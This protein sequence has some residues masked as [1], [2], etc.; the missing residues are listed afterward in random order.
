MELLHGTAHTLVE[1]MFYSLV[2]GAVLALFVALVLRLIPRKNAGTRFALWFSV[3]LAMIVLPFAGGSA[4]TAMAM[5]SQ[6]G[7]AGGSLITIPISW[8]LIIFVVWALCA[9]LALAR[10]V[11]GLWHIGRLRRASIPIDPAMLGPDIQKLIADFPRP[12]SLRLS[13]AV[14]VPTAIGFSQPAIVLPR[15]FLEEISGAE[16]KQVLLHE[17]TH[18]RRHDDWTNLIQK[19]VK[20]M[21]F[22]NPP[23]L[24]IE[25]RL[26]LEREMACD[27]AVLAQAVG[28][29]EYA[30]CLRH[31]AERSFLRR[32][33]ALAQSMVNRMRQLSLRM[34]HILDADRPRSTRLWKPAIPLVVVAASLCGVSAWNGPA[35]V[36]FK[37]DGPTVASTLTASSVSNYDIHPA[38]VREAKLTLG[39][40]DQ[41]PTA[42][43]RA[44]ISAKKPVGSLAN[45]RFLPPSTTD[46]PRMILTNATLGQ[47][48]PNQPVRSATTPPRADYV[49][50]E[51][52]FVTMTGSQQNW[53]VQVWQV[54][55]LRPVN[56]NPSK[57]ITRK[58][59]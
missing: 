53:R 25:H 43:I 54:R 38:Q 56:N 18:L 14:Q 40:N 7:I 47:T 32:Q 13:G 55:V 52:F 42:I 23:A 30:S 16:L 24:W 3:L 28:P 12:I 58:N 46:E 50:S 26:S 9:G 11:A 22:F 19:V 5:S 49:V 4:R 48:R 45:A 17:L 37:S 31:V 2:E 29:Q 33:L 8:V 57:S 10:L 27:E 44:H 15:W 59:I 41:H 51:Q 36:G 35:I 21:L 34:T 39:H 6:K 1:W 20:A